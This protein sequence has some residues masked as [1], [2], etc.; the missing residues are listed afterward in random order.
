MVEQAE[1]A[2]GQPLTEA[3]TRE[4]R[5][6]LE[7][8]IAQSLGLLANIIMCDYLNPWNDPSGKTWLMHRMQ[9]I[10]QNIT[11]TTPTHRATALFAGRTRFMRKALSFELRANIRKRRP[12]SPNT[13]V[14]PNP[15][16]ARRSWRLRGCI[17][18]NSTR[19]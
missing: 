11:P 13:C 15:S 16:A 12:L 8:G 4:I 3:N 9:L 6:Q 1:S 19:R 2:Y 7:C 10:Q 5:E 14:S 18:E 17:M